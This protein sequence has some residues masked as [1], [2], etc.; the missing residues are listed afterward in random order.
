MQRISRRMSDEDEAEFQ[1]YEF[2][3]KSL[4]LTPMSGKY[5]RKSSRHRKKG[6]RSSK[7]ERC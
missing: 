4:K 1:L 6:R 5:I 7:D 2:V 3:I